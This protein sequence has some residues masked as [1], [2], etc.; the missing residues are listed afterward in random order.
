MGQRD[1][2]NAFI[3]IS[4]AVKCRIL[5]VVGQLGAGGLERQLYLLLRAM[6]RDRYRPEVV[7]WNF[8]AEDI[9][10]G[11]IREL[12]IPLHSFPAIFTRT[13]KLLGLRRIALEKRPEIIHSYTFHTNFAAWWAA[14]ASKAIP[15]GAVRSDFTND[16]KACGLVLGTLSARLPNTQVYNSFASAEKARR[17]G[18]LFTAHN[19][20]VVRNGLDLTEFRSVP[21][22]NNGSP[23]ILGIGSL[24]QMKRWDRLVRAAWSL[25]NMGLDCSVEIVGGGPLRESLEKQVQDLGLLHQVRLKGHVDNIPAVLASSTFL[26]H[27][28]EIEGSPNVV[29]EAM[30]C[31]RAVVAMDAGDIPLLIEDGKTGFVVPRGDDDKFVERLATLIQNRDLCRQMG[32]AG[33]AKAE[34]EFRTNRLVEKTFAAYVAAGWSD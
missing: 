32:E 21:I 34:R 24:L 6:D 3:S 5:Y 23:R 15:V 17:S 9:Y 25:K 12:G 8:R 14:A 18:Y 13:K 10:V 4:T 7:V 30:A 11:R 16:K 20:I 22:S 27:S 1:S 29:M 19:I 26:A 31:G 2:T 33:R 28:S